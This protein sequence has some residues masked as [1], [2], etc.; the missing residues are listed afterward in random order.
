[1]S[2]LLIFKCSTLVALLRLLSNDTDMMYYND[3]L[4]NKDS[5]VYISNCSYLV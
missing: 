2:A 4:H 3:E 1:M 5:I